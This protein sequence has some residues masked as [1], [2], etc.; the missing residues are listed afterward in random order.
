MIG[1]AIGDRIGKIAAMSDDRK[2]KQRGYQDEE[3]RPQ[4]PGPSKSDTGIRTP[5]FTAYRESIRCDECGAELNTQLEISFES[6]CPKC[7]AALHICRNCLNLDPAGRYECAK[8][9]EKRVAN[10]RAA[11]RCPMFEARRVQVKETSFSTTPSRDD[12]RKAL[13]DLFKKK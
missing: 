8:P 5:N 2:Y 4:Q 10:K 9:V 1:L 3:P 12:A 6:R 13:D 7:R 11:N